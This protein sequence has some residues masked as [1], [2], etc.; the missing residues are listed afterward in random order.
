MRYIEVCKSEY[1]S[2]TTLENFGDE[3]ENLSQRDKAGT[4][5]MAKV[6]NYEKE[7]STNG[8]FSRNGLKFTFPDGRTETEI[9]TLAASSGPPLYD[10]CK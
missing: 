8:L 5:K 3:L 7:R 1:E 6:Y 10:D 4:S 2:S 9:R